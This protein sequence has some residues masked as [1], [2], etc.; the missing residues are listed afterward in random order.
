MMFPSMRMMSQF[1]KVRLSVFQPRN[2]C[3]DCLQRIV[4]LLFM[5]FSVCPIYLQAQSDNVKKYLTDIPTSIP[6]GGI[7]VSETGITNLDNR[8]KWTVSPDG[9]YGAE[10]L[11][12][13]NTGLI[14]TDG[15]FQKVDP[16]TGFT[17]SIDVFFADQST[18][19]GNFKRLIDT[20][21][22]VDANNVIHT[23]PDEDTRRKHFFALI[24]GKETGYLAT[25]FLINENGFIDG[26][27][28]NRYS[29]DQNGAHYDE[30]YTAERYAKLGY[31]QSYANTTT[32]DF[33]INDN[34]WHNLMLNIRAEGT[35]YLYL[36]GKLVYS[37]AKNAAV[38][39][40]MSEIHNFQ[41]VGLGNNPNGT[42]N[43]IGWIRNVQIVPS[44]EFARLKLSS[45]INN[46]NLIAKS[47]PVRTTGILV[48][49]LEYI[50]LSEEPATGYYLDWETVKYKGLTESEWTNINTT[51][52]TFQMPDHDLEL[53]GE[54]KPNNYTIN[55]VLDDPD[56]RYYLPDDPD[57]TY[58]VPSVSKGHFEAFTVSS[59]SL[60]K[61]KDNRIYE[62]LGWSKTEHK[63]TPD[64]SDY[65][66]G[67]TYAVG[68]AL[69]TA[70]NGTNHGDAISL[71]PIWREKTYTISVDPTMFGGTVSLKNDK[72][73]VTGTSITAK[74]AEKIII[75][76]TPDTGLRYQTIRKVTKREGSNAEDEITDVNGVFS[77]NVDNSDVVV[78]TVF[79]GPWS[80]KL[81]T[82]LPNDGVMSVGGTELSTTPITGIIGTELRIVLKCNSDYKL[83]KFFYRVRDDDHGATNYGESTEYTNN[84]NIK[85]DV[86]RGEYT[87]S[88]FNNTGSLSVTAT[89][90][91]KAEL[92]TATGT[93]K[94]VVV[95]AAGDQDQTWTGNAIAPPYTLKM[96]SAEGVDAE[97]NAFTVSFEENN[98]TYPAT[99]AGAINA[100]SAKAVITAKNSKDYKGH[101]DQ[102]NAFTIKGDLAYSEI[103][104]EDVYYTGEDITRDKLAVRA[105]A[106]GNGR[107]LTSGAGNLEVD[108]DTYP[109]P[110]PKGVGDYTVKIKAASGSTKFKSSKTGV[111]F[112]VITADLASRL[113]S[114]Y[115]FS[116]GEQS[117]QEVKPQQTQ[118]TPPTV[119][120]LK[121]VGATGNMA[122]TD[123][124]LAYVQPDGAQLQGN[125]V[126]ANTFGKF[127]VAIV[128]RGSNTSGYVLTNYYTTFQKSEAIAKYDWTT[129][130]TNLYNLTKPTGY[131]IYQVMTVETNKV[132][133]Q[134]VGYI[135]KNVPV[136]LYKSGTGN[137][138]TIDITLD[139]ADAGSYDLTATTQ[140]KG[141]ASALDVSTIT[142]GDVYILN[143]N[144]FV[145]TK[146]GT[147]PA[148]RCYL[149]LNSSSAR[150]LSIGGED[151]DDTTGIMNAL[152]DLQE[153][154]WYDLN[155]RSLDGPQGKGV[156][157]VNGRKV[158]IK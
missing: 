51:T 86:D 49:M 22:Y 90:A 6:E 34:K 56:A 115:S 119:S 69:N 64:A 81:E 116:G 130:Y 77:F 5:L 43:F 52:H 85:Y 102:A 97:A 113:Q 138:G 15:P 132:T 61:T 27:W 20:S 92:S 111:S 57:V 79:N 101:I 60:E 9:T 44:G 48:P 128:A 83:N 147:I 32:S 129:Y 135:P 91:E 19:T 26:Y 149:L 55:Y 112:S 146:S 93:N 38:E 73:G 39:T 143:G 136:L 144:K 50:E 84:S 107:T 3:K 139:E 74:H 80:I 13:S 98:E 126:P 59:V 118:L 11:G 47:L 68:T 35:R 154:Q 72:T 58:S 17:I 152:R 33:D 122:T 155:G 14:I 75:T 40:I 117:V 109:N 28:I 151:S 153:E 1:L 53:T 110:A 30:H 70:L 141:T 82:A 62:L 148:N 94:P 45:Q 78:N 127:Y 158:I 29:T 150:S 41:L 134:E 21:V 8:I 124:K 114:G 120:N 76:S 4:F 24:G 42:E 36:D 106:S 121:L 157:I 25:E 65:S 23:S 18:T 142:T 108:A 105:T 104:I 16:T 2:C 71:H 66:I 133:I 87:I 12:T 125:T 156:Y 103:V 100:G 31:V 99:E 96:G 54:F 63:E 89:F 7:V 140:F 46:G 88:M 95:I 131:T 67:A 37:C 10:F 123:Y 145:R 137:S